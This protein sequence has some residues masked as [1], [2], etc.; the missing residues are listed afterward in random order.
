MCGVACLPAAAGWLWLR[1]IG[2][3]LDALAR[4]ALAASPPAGQ[5]APTRRDPLQPAFDTEQSLIAACL[6]GTLAL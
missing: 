5:P 3:R 4:Q 6:L 1:Q 2:C